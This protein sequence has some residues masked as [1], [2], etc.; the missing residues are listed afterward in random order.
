MMNTCWDCIKFNDPAC[1][2]LY[3]NHTF[4]PNVTCSRFYLKPKEGTPMGFDF[5]SWF[6]NVIRGNGRTNHLCA[7]K[8]LYDKMREWGFDA[9][10]IN[11]IGREI[12]IFSHLGMTNVA[13]IDSHFET[14]ND[15]PRALKSAFLWMYEN[16][17]K[18]QE[19]F[20]CDGCHI[21][22]LKIHYIHPSKKVPLCPECFLKATTPKEKC[23]SEGPCDKAKIVWGEFGMANSTI[24]K[25][26]ISYCPF[27]GA[28]R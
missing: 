21:E 15:F 20:K 13:K 7:L 18:K 3:G 11:W 27:C 5:D 8:P 6:D 25:V 28:K 24:N 22:M 12:N 9:I 1:E 16:R 23:D 19:I 2:Y 4:S 26:D 10:T 17:V 14:I